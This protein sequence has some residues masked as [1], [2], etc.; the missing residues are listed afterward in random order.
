[1][2]IGWT[3]RF[4]NSTTIHCFPPNLAA[5]G[6]LLHQGYRCTPALI[7]RS[8]DEK[9]HRDGIYQVLCGACVKSER[10]YIE[11]KDAPEGAGTKFNS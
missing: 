8:P 1:M 6:S 3:G 5:A 2:L 11:E 7:H 10:K 4:R 9:G